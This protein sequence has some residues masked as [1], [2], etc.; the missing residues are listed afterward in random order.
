LRE[1]FSWLNRFTL[2]LLKPHPGKGSRIMKRRSCGWN[3]E[4][5][6]HTLT[7]IGSE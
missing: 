5:L 2:S 7:G 6:L 1:N 4:F 3:N